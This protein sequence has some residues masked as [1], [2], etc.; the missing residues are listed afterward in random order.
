MDQPTSFVPGCLHRCQRH[1]IEC[2]FHCTL[3]RLEVSE[4]N[5]TSSPSLT[6]FLFMALRELF[7]AR[8]LWFASF[9]NPN[10]W[11]DQVVFSTDFSKCMRGRAE[12]PKKCIESTIYCRNLGFAPFCSFNPHADQVFLS[13]LHSVCD[14]G[15]KAKKLFIRLP[16]V[17]QE[18][19]DVNSLHFRQ[20]CV[21]SAV[22]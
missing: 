11:S 19:I 16:S 10:L 3:G 22:E 4:W 9:C 20:L 5:Y 21:F 14:G 15:P 8:D 6:K 2:P 18:S 12:A 7:F 17:T 1:Y 13:H